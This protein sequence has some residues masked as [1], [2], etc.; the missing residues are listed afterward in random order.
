MRYCGVMGSDKFSEDQFQGWKL[1]GELRKLLTTIVPEQKKDQGQGGPQRLLTRD[2]YLCAFLFAQFNPVIDSMRGMCACSHL[3]RVCEEVSTRPI[4]LGSFSEAQAVFGSEALEKLFSHLIRQN[5]EALGPP[6]G[7]RHARLTA[8]DSTIIRAIPRMEWAE[9]RHQKTTQRAVRLHLKFHLFDNQPSGARVTEGRRCERLAFEEMIEPG[10]F[11]V[12]DRYYGRDYQ[13][14]GKL[15]ESD[16]GYAIRLMENASQ[17]LLEELAVEPEDLAAGVVSDR[18]VHLG[19][20]KC[21]HHGPVRVVTIEPPG[22]GETLHIVTNRLDRESHSAALIANIYRDRWR[23]ELFFR[24]LKCIFGRSSQ[25]HWFA[26]SREGV[27]IQIYTA[28]IAALLLAR[29]LGRLPNKREMELL[30][31]YSLGVMD[32][33]ELSKMLKQTSRKAKG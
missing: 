7:S 8:I 32:A 17:T 11:Y 12:G 22:G 28:L 27:A 30:R 4:S 21:W 19:A 16:C 1:V 26:E 5:P 18:M 2:D 29:R 10:E 25:W 9:W 31:F 3:P 14:L 13:L 33:P 23:I 24:W 6:L 20:R 15:N